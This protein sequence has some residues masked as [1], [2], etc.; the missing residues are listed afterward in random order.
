M[1]NRIIISLSILMFLYACGSQD[2][3]KTEKPQSYQN[4][5]E[6]KNNDSLSLIR[7]DQE[8][9]DDNVSIWIY[10]YMADTIIQLRKLKRDTLT[11]AKLIH[12]INAKY[13]D[14][15]KL[16]YVKITNDTIYV[17][18]DNSDY[19]TQ[20]MGTTGADEYMISS[21]FTLTEMA[22]IKY[23]NFEFELGEHASPGTYGR[24]HYLDLI[25]K[26]KEMNKK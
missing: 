14:K 15:V 22:N 11:S 13:R 8:I 2:N 3:S 12:L 1:I 21:T 6:T 24:K 25:R 16:D 20:Q 18:I 5:S 26:N 19:L 17:K 7:T 10:D 4:I 23:V 9:K